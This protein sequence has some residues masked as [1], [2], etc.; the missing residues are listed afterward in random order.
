MKEKMV[1]VCLTEW[2]TTLSRNSLD[3]CVPLKKMDFSYL[4]FY[5]LME[6]LNKGTAPINLV[7]VN[8]V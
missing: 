4:C 1:I 8:K 7:E 6:S 2:L 5:R 3:A